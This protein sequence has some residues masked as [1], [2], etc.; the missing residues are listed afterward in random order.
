M[1]ALAAQLTTKR[2]I[3]ALLCLIL[4]TSV[5]NASGDIWEILDA[6]VNFGVNPSHP[7][8]KGNF[9]VTILNRNNG[10]ARCSGNFFASPDY[11]HSVMQMSCGLQKISDSDA[12]KNDNFVAHG[13]PTG[14]GYGRPP[15]YAHINPN[16]G[17]GELCI[18]VISKDQ[19]VC[20]AFTDG[21]RN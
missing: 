21:I 18:K 9:E 17:V 1:H 12:I 7:V 16:S 2:R 19:W 14:E 10:I 3:V 11:S 5:A 6:H 8:D 13:A 4:A 20:G 15:Y